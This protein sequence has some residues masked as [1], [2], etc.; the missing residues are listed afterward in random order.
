MH[1]R[2]VT[3]R[4]HLLLQ[5]NTVDPAAHEPVALACRSLESRPVDLDQAS[6]IG[7]DRARRA[8]FAG[9]LRHRCSPH[10]KKFRERLLRQGQDVTVNPI[11]DVQQPPCQAC[12]DR[13]QCI[14]GRNVLELGEQRP[15]V[16]LNR[17]FQ[18]AAMAKRRDKRPFRG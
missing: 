7:S 4:R 3:A 6:P 8:E 17:V 16:G 14:A 5:N 1:R 10:A 18:G 11:V 2:G 12:L 15:E 9:N 13:V